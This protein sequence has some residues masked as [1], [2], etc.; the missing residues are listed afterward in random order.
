MPS[1][2]RSVVVLPEPFAPSSPNV[3][4]GRTWKLSRSTTVWSPKRMLKS[5]TSMAGVSS[6]GF[7]LPRPTDSHRRPRNCRRSAEAGLLHAL[8]KEAL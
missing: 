7:T 4:P 3:S 6:M 2:A 1:S 5:R 8:D